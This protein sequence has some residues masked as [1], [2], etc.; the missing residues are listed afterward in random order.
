MNLALRNHALETLYKR[1]FEG[2]MEKH[3]LD[4]EKKLFS[5]VDIIYILLWISIGKIKPKCKFV[6]RLLHVHRTFQPTDDILSQQYPMI[7][8]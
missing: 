7:A 1:G 8:D 6:S 5:L 3:F 4:K 2:N